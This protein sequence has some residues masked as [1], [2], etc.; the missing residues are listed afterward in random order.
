MEKSTFSNK[1][2]VSIWQ[3]LTI[4]NFLLLFI[5]ENISVFGDQLYLVALPWLTIELTNSG[6]SLGTVLMAAAIPR[7]IFLLVGGA[8]SDRTSPRLVMLVANILRALLTI[9]LTLIVWYQATQLWHLYL[10]S[11]CFGTLEGFFIPAVQSIIPRIVKKDQLIASNALSQGTNQLILLIGPGLGGLLIAVSG[12]KMAFAIDAVTFI[13]S[14]ATLSLMK[15]SSNFNTVSKIKETNTKNQSL[16][17]EILG[18]IT[19]VREGLKYGWNN[20]ALRTILLVVMVYNLIFIGPLRVGFASLAHSRFLGGAVALGI[21]NSAWGG[22]N[23]LGALMPSLLRNPLRIGTLLLI[24]GGIQGLG[25]FILGFA[26]N[27]ILA[28]LIIVL[29]GFC[30]GFFVVKQITWIQ[31]QTPPE[32]LGRVTSFVML[33]SFGIAPFSFAIAGLLVNV[34]LTILFTVTGSIILFMIALL[35]LNPSVRKIE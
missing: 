23:L 24:L 32:I 33:S 20:L 31:K 13:F 18:L 6:L 30:S 34:N 11:I 21:M 3:P 29:L 2:Q 27:I 8:I 5:G 4:R 7:A 35:A 26:P 19:G 15:V 28:S 12:I 9:I 1:N 10:F 14:I 17:K 16:S 25:L 22:G